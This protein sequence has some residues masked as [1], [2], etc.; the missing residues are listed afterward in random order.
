MAVPESYEN[1]QPVPLTAELSCRD[2]TFT[3]DAYMK[4]CFLEGSSEQVYATKRAGLQLIGNL[5]T[6]QNIAGGSGLGLANYK[7]QSPGGVV[8][9]VAIIGDHKVNVSGTS[10][11][12]VLMAVKQTLPI[13]SPHPTG[14]YYRLQTYL[15]GIGTNTY[16]QSNYGVVAI[17]GTTPTNNVL[18]TA[19][20]SGSYLLTPSLCT[21]DN[22]AYVMDIAGNISS[23]AIGGPST[24]WP[25]LNTVIAYPEGARGTALWQHLNYL[26][27]FSTDSFRVYADAGISPG[28]PIQIVAN[29]GGKVGI[30]VGAEYTLQT[31]E[32]STYFLGQSGATGLAVY[33]MDGLEPAMIS[34]PVINRVLQTA[35]QAFMN[36]YAGSVTW[37]A[38]ITGTMLQVSGQ[39]FY[40]LSLPTDSNSGSVGRT[41]VY[42]MQS[43]KWYWWTQ[44]NP[45]TGLEQEIRINCI[46]PAAGTWANFCFDQ[47]N[48]RV[49]N[50][51]QTTYRDDT[52][53]IP[54]AIQTDVYNWGN[55]R[56]KMIPATYIVT[57]QI[58][59]TISISWTD[60]DYSSFNTPQVVNGL[61]P[62]KQ[63]IRCG[64]TLQR[65]WLIT[66]SDNTP[67]RFYNLEVEVKPGAL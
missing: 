43:R 36:Y 42:A 8:A 13:P 53:N 7:L 63:L 47:S 28:A 15:E 18:Y 51:L 50:W 67:M 40:A 27:A 57:D 39:D 59:T 21:L 65:G 9:G 1:I 20:G 52:A 3:T 2:A 55:M 6:G 31:F 37:N 24:G 44:V 38:V 16:A 25:A 35:F 41:L 12:T 22:T 33:R 45:V 32:K 56:T 4:N 66:H 60:N 49:Y 17:G 30:P 10:L 5:S 23:T 26:V 61:L 48:G 54:V 58:A 19:L 46:T 34:T 64:S 29:T 14:S 11:S 62:K